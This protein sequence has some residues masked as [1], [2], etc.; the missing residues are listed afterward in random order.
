MTAAS[1]FTLATLWKNGAMIS[2][3][4]GMDN[5][6]AFAVSVVGSDV[7][8]AGIEYEPLGAIPITKIWKNGVATALSD[9]VAFVSPARI[10][11]KSQ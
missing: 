5:S 7:Y 1:L 2:V 6:Q 9:G 8:V 4:D 10:F 11:I 3:G